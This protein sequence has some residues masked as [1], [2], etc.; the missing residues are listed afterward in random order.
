MIQY[1]KN[2]GFTLVELMLATAFI[3][4]LL[5]A[6]IVVV[7]QIGSIF[8]RGLTLKAVNH[9]GMVAV[10]D[11]KRVIGQSQS[12]DMKTQTGGY[13]L[14]TG[15]YTYAL[16]FGD[17]GPNTLNSSNQIRLVR[18][19]DPNRKYCSNT[20]PNSYG[21]NVT[22]SIIYPAD[23]PVELLTN[24]SLKVQSFSARSLTSNPGGSNLYSVSIT[25]SSG[26]QV[27]I[28]SAGD[29]CKAPKDT[30]SNF[31]FCAV[32][33]FDFTVLTNNKDR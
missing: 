11:M 24:S 19:S 30:G 25:I 10:D 14:C 26:N 4:V 2:R 8:N 18:I 17:N 1:R 21:F 32:N 23:K 27:W 29:K 31:D 9:A 22:P 5:L 3:S 6:I 33:K 28:E 16:N 13:R 7:I 12:I 15:K 20:G